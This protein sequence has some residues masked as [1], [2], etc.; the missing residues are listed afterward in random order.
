MVEVVEA[1]A[2]E[3]KRRRRGD[4]CRTRHASKWSLRIR[5]IQHHCFLHS[6][7]LV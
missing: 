7:L 1:A 3:S 5:T 6:H 4:E 2:R